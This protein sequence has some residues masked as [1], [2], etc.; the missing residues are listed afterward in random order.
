VLSGLGI[1]VP[2]LLVILLRMYDAELDWS[3]Q[4]IMPPWVAVLLVGGSA[5][6][7]LVFTVEVFRRT[8]H[9]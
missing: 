8:S 5:L 2:I 9:S 3:R 7:F 6:A 4:P 1:A